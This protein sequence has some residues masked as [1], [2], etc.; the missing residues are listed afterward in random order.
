M[1]AVKAAFTETLG[2]LAKRYGD[3]P[4]RWRWGDEHRALL[5]NQ[6][7]DH[8]PGFKPLFG[9]DFP[10]DGGFYSVNRGGTV[11]QVNP[12]HPLRR[13]SGAGYRGIYD[14]ANPEQSRFIIATGQSGHPLSRH[15]ADQLPLWRRGEGI[16]LHISEA[17]LMAGKPEVLV[18]HP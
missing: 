9:L 13:N 16:R 12:E 5:P 6:V 1:G 2:D 4:A 7:M 14:L 3:D 11:G 18:F 8:V 17:E 15:Y 10:S